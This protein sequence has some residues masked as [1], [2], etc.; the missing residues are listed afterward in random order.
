MSDPAPT[1]PSPLV[2]AYR[3]GEL[4]NCSRLAARSLSR[5]VPWYSFWIVLG[6]MVFVIGF[7][8]LGVQKA[9]RISAAEVPDVLLAAYV[10]F[11]FGAGL[12]A[13]LVYRRLWRIARAAEELAGVQWEVTFADAG[14]VWKS[15]IIETCMSWRAVKSVEAWREG[16]LIWGVQWRAFVIP[17]RIFADSAARQAFVTAVQTEIERARGTPS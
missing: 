1:F 8:V 17:S 5:I 15:D 10:A 14:I 6:A 9:G 7:A 11:A 13:L 4:T 12:A 3:Q 16:V 2:F